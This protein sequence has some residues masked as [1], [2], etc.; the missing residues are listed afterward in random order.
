V[1]ADGRLFVRVVTPTE[2]AG[3]DDRTEGFFAVPSR[4]A[5]SLQRDGITAA[6]GQRREHPTRGSSARS[7][8][9]AGGTVLREHHFR[10]DGPDPWRC[11]MRRQIVADG[12]LWEPGS[13]RPRRLGD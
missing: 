4:R 8:A 3:G 12:G 6:E 2:P 7:V 13:T 10:S 1:L 11:R 9:V 5:G